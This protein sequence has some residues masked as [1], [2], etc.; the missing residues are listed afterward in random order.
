[1]KRHSVQKN[2]ETKAVNAKVNIDEN[3]DACGEFYRNTLAE[4]QDYVR[5]VQK[6]YKLAMT[7]EDDE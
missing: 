3:V 1:M 2:V 6:E 5:K 7:E 4:G